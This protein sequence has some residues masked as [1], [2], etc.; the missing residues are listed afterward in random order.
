MTTIDTTLDPGSL[1][2]L[3]AATRA[4]GKGT[5]DQN[6]FLKLM[7]TQLQAQDPFAPMDTQSMMT[8]MSQLSTNSGI[9]EMNTSL[10]SITDSLSALS[11]RMSGAAAW[12]GHDALIASD[13]VNP[14]TAGDY[15][16]QINLSQAATDV[17]ID[18]LDTKGLIVHSAEAGAA[19][20]GAVN[21]DW[22][23]QG[24][25][26]MVTGPLKVRVIARNGAAIVPTTT[27]VWTPIRAVQS[28]SG[29][30]QQ[31]VTANGTIDPENAIALD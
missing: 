10:K 7:T 9:S 30:A 20:G 25:S 12:L 15:R 16:G 28:P 22:D 24:A 5:L 27:S 1:A 17:T 21:F 31:L 8:Q 4:R 19:P 3:N 2:A 23:G 13:F 29:A 18:L 14:G 26:G 11:T 6:D